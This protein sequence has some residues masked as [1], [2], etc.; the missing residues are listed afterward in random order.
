M[1]NMNFQVNLQGIIDLLSN[2]LYSDPGVFIRE[3]LQNGV[4]A[5]TARRKLGHQYEE[6]VTVELFPS[7]HTLSLQDNGAGLTLQEIEQFLARIGSTTKKGDLDAAEAFI[8]QFGVGLLACFVVSDEI[9]LITRSAADGDS[10]EW[11]GKPDGTYAIK[12]LNNQ[13]PIGTTVYLKAKP[14]YEDYFEY[15]RVS[16]LLTRYGQFLPTP[17]YLTEGGNEERINESL[18]PWKLDR[19]GALDYIEH[20]AYYKPMDAIPLHSAIG[21]VEGVAY[22]LPYAVSLQDEKRHQVYLKNM[23]LSDKMATILPPWAFFVNGIMNTDSLRPTASREAFQENDLFFLVRDELGNCIK[24]HLIGLSEQDP[25]L[26]KRIIL[27]HYASLKAMAVEDEELYE[28]II[29]YLNFETSY[30][31]MSMSDILS[32][33][34]EILVTTTLDEFRQIARVARSQGLM[35]INGGYVH[36]FEL[37]RKLPSVSEDVDVSILDILAIANRFE[38]LAGEERKALEPFRD[39]ADA[40]LERFQCRCSIRWFEPADIPALYTTNEEV[41]LFKLA[42]DSEREANALFAS[43]V[44]VIRQELYDE[45]FARLCFNYNNPIVRKAAASGDIELQKVCIELFYTQALLMGNHSMNAEELRLMNESLL[46]FM[47]RG[48]DEAVG[49]AR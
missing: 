46:H 45:P 6:R 34:P 29:R 3:L 30:G 37:V 32:S 36:D 18:P 22:I 24:Q 35:V 5:I 41:N 44:Q 4:D 11:R 28:L 17:I 9:V 49:G 7:S 12:K 13:A 39:L 25:E 10:L 14:E 16:D 38:R 40:L 31:D 42:D 20:S 43:I 23:L 15:D 47:N 8:G 27:I 1:E 26:L 33:Y 2:H 21:G 48:L 19:A